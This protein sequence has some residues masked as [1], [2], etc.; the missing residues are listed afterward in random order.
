MICNSNVWDDTWGTRRNGRD[1]HSD[2]ISRLAGVKPDLLTIGVN[3]L[4]GVNLKPL[5]AAVEVTLKAS[6]K[7]APPVTTAAKQNS[8]LSA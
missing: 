4:A 7:L 5:A 2:A 6:V 8:L 1:P 3:G